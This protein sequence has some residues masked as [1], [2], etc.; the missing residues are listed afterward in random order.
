[1]SNFSFAL[2]LF[3]LVGVMGVF[4]LA[5]S[6]HHRRKQMREAGFDEVIPFLAPTHLCAMLEWTDPK[7]E[8]YLRSRNREPE[9][10][11]IQRRQLRLLIETTKRILRNSGLLQDLAAG[12]LYAENILLAK[13]AEELIEVGAKVRIY[14]LSVL[15]RLYW[16][17]AVLALGPLAFS[18]QLAD[19][20][21]TV[22]SSLVPTYQQLKSKIVDFTL[23]R[24][25][26][27][28]EQLIQNL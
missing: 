4:A 25:A 3:P 16:K 14:S 8:S 1:M 27:F 23:L 26:G 17:K 24:S 7:N 2:C 13:L 11:A 9:F 12:Q 28:V 18:T 10:R 15:M 20:E 22:S 5:L 6:K 19:L 21:K